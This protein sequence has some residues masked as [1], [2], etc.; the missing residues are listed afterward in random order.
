MNT[1]TDAWEPHRLGAYVSNVYRLV[2]GAADDIVVGYAGIA[3][4]ALC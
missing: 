4:N 3:C 2:L 1:I